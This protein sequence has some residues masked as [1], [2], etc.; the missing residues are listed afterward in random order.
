M[1]LRRVVDSRT[2]LWKAKDPTAP[3]LR[4]DQH[5]RIAL[6]LDALVWTEEQ[7]GWWNDSVAYQRRRWKQIKVGVAAIALAAFLVGT[8]VYWTRSDAFQVRAAF[9]AAPVRDVA[10]SSRSEDDPWL[11]TLQGWVATL[12]QSGRESEA[13]AAVDAAFSGSCLSATIAAERRASHGVD[14][15]VLAEVETLIREGTSQSWQCLSLLPLSGRE[16]AL[17]VEAAKGFRP[18]DRMNDYERDRAPIEVARLLVKLGDPAAAR[19]QALR[20]LD[21]IGRAEPAR[22]EYLAARLAQRVRV[23]PWPEVRN[24][25]FEHS[26]PDGYNAQRMKAALEL[27][28]V[29]IGGVEEY[30]RNRG[31]IRSV[32]D[33]YEAMAIG[34]VFARAIHEGRV[35]DSLKALDR[36]IAP[37]SEEPVARRALA[38]ILDP[39][40][41]ELASSGRV[42]EALRIADRA[43]A[44]ASQIESEEARSRALANVACLLAR[45]GRLLRAREI[46]DRCQRSLD[47]LRA[48]TAIVRAG[49]LGDKA[50]RGRHVHDGTVTDRVPGVPTAAINRGP[51]V[52]FSNADALPRETRAELEDVAQR[53][54]DYMADVGFD[55][56]APITV[57]GS[58]EFDV[59]DD[60]RTITTSRTTA[61]PMMIELGFGSILL[62]GTAALGSNLHEALAVYYA[63]SFGNNSVV[64]I[65]GEQPFD[66][67]APAGAVGTP[68]SLSVA[69]AL[70]DVRSALGAA[71][72][73]R[74][75]RV[76][77]E[78]LRGRS[79][80]ADDAAFVTSLISSAPAGGSADQIRDILKR[81]GFSR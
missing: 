22:R 51:A 63:A 75:I 32:Y 16:K 18:D 28:E 2:E 43:L 77:L 5:R 71:T 6:S 10:F 49:E 79:S 25:I 50:G 70:W 58:D 12:V 54:L 7:R 61:T 41:R 52:V 30:V 65:P 15:E 19:D 76:A 48:Y 27:G 36:T 74:L 39:V 21:T 62:S 31:G 33:D 23:T 46:A 64:Q 72:A 17:A 56:G 11:E 3:Q 78:G 34:E 57:I 13:E 1:A 8:W 20:A 66:L 60:D 69:P 68:E 24:R 53:F 44:S 35:E 42:D 9:A 55:R 67:A 73:D 37:L 59:D 38:A 45:C 40:G 4:S 80:D 81:H 26:T 29:T 47:R 14:Q